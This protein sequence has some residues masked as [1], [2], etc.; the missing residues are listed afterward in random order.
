MPRMTFFRRTKA[1]RGQGFA[2][3]MLVVMMLVILLAMVVEVGFLLNNY[4]HVFD[5]AREAARYS[6][7]S[8]PIQDNGASD[9]LFFDRTAVQAMR[10]MYPMVL[11]GN[12]QAGHPLG[13]DIVISVF[14]VSGGHVD[15]YPSAA[16][17][18]LCA[19]HGDAEIQNN[20][21]LG[22]IPS[23]YMDLWTV[24]IPRSSGFTDEQIEA[25]L[26][27]AAPATG[28]LLVE[29]YFHEY[30]LLNIIPDVLPINPFQLSVY[31]VM[32]LAAAE[33]TATP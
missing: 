14:S 27:P 7:V 25:R 19:N 11:E 12:P 21:P 30:Q 8:D 9:Q 29:I 4:L 33:P 10:V 23:V 17:W 16:G 22:L 28:V 15:R 24:C 32:P 2:E 18:S 1:K 20:L 26:E 3:L 31:S 13:D 5:A 6:S